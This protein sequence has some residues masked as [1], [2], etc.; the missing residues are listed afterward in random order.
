[1]MPP[2]VSCDGPTFYFHSRQIVPMPERMR[3]VLICTE[4]MKKSDHLKFGT[5]K[6]DDWGKAGEGN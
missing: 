2:I 5:V 1:M 3:Q 6:S 4:L